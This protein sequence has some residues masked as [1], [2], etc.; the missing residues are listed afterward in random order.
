MFVKAPQK[1]RSWF[2]ARVPSLLLA[3]ARTRDPTDVATL[4]ARLR[5][6]VHCQHGLDTTESTV[7][8]QPEN[9]CSVLKYGA[10]VTVVREPGIVREVDPVIHISSKNHPDQSKDECNY[11]SEQDELCCARDAS[12]NRS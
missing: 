7:R 4:V 2:R 5:P 12:K 8:L 9:R 1:R 3:V 11:Q 6:L 10:I